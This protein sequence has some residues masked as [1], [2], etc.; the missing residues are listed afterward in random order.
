MKFC[1]KDCN[2]YYQYE[3]KE[4]LIE[5]IILYFQ[6]RNLYKI[7]WL[8]YSHIKNLI[9]YTTGIYDNKITRNL[10]TNL[11]N[12]DLFEKKIVY[13]SVLYRFNPNKKKNIK[14]DIIKLFF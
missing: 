8:K 1:D 4:L 12:L 10:W 7:G 9:K 5:L 2:L 11:L 6:Y 13:K 3:D 14:P